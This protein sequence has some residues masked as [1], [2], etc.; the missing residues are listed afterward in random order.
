MLNNY[1]RDLDQRMLIKEW[2]ITMIRT[3][4]LVA[5]CAAIVSLSAAIAADPCSRPMDGDWVWMSCNGTGSKYNRSGYAEGDPFIV[6]DEFGFNRGNST[7]HRK[8]G[9]KLVQLSGV[10]VTKDKIVWNEGISSNGFIDRVTM[11]Y[12]ASRYYGPDGGPWLGHNVEGRCSMIPPPLF[13][14]CLEAKILPQKPQF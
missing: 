7:L 3:A 1:S 4:S 6:R 8:E 5:F 11:S 12:R 9:A 13:N 10:S 14:Q 2:K